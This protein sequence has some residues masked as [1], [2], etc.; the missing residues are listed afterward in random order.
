MNPLTAM[1]PKVRSAVYWVYAVVGILFGALQVYQVNAI[2]GESLVK[3]MAVYAYLGTALAI[4][5]GSNMPSAQD[6]ADGDAPMP[7]PE[8][9]ERGAIDTGTAIVIGIFVVLV[10]I[11]AGAIR[12]G[13]RCCPGLPFSGLWG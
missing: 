8:P 6:V 4:T 10:L 1:P 7:A 5:A 9:D 2:W 3:V 13:W 12:L 11:L